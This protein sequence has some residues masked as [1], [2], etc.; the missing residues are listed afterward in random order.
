MSLGTAIASGV[1]G[2][3]G[4]FGRKKRQRKQSS[5]EKK[6]A[7]M[8]IDANKDLAKYGYDQSRA[9][10]ARENAYNTPEQQMARFKEAGLN[11]NLI[12]G[13]GDAGNAS[14]MQAYQSPTADYTGVSNP[15]MGQMQHQQSTQQAIQT[16]MSTLEAFINTKQK[17]AETDL[18]AKKAATEKWRKHQTK[19]QTTLT[20]SQE[21]AQFYKNTQEAQLMGMDDTTQYS[22]DG[23]SNY[24]QRIVDQEYSKIRMQQNNAT[25]AEAEAA[26]KN[27]QISE[28]EKDQIIRGLSGAASVIKLGKK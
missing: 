22:G 26:Y 25:R 14:S 19:A 28:Y 8:S 17:A 5:H 18:T 13:Q 1:A 2:I 4:L 10:W 27:K 6:M 21:T 12:Y 3:A 7:Q 9:Q 16:S 20:K 24:N 23:L 11:P 15:E